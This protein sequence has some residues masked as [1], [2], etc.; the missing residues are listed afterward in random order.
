MDRRGQL[1]LTRKSGGRDIRRMPAIGYGLY[2][3]KNC[4]VKTVEKEGIEYFEDDIHVAIESEAEGAL[5]LHRPGAVYI[6]CLGKHD[7]FGT[8]S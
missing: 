5:I 1:P 4:S 2:G 8:Q 6:N 7:H 3:W